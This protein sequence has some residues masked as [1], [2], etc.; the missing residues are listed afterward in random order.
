M[1]GK[2]SDAIPDYGEEA[3]GGDGQ[4]SESGTVSPSSSSASPKRQVRIA[5][6][7]DGQTSSTSSNTAGLASLSRILNRKD[8]FD[9]GEDTS[10]AAAGETSTDSLL[11]QRQG[12]DASV[13]AIREVMLSFL[14][15][16]DEQ[17]ESVQRIEKLLEGVVVRDKDPDGGE[18]KLGDGDE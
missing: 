9:V 17:A 12:S 4:H 1:K 6:T 2:V 16:L 8:T 15:R 3:D 5:T 14:E 13:Q 11:E 10:G 7:H 18:K